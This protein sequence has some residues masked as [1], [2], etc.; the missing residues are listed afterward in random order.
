MLR[1]RQMHRLSKFA[2][3]HSSVY[4]HFDVERSLTSR[5]HYKQPGAAALAEWQVLCAG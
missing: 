4:D 5:H 2:S 1:S 3:V